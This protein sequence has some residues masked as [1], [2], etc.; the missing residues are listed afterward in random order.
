[1]IVLTCGT[2][3]LFHIGHLKVLQRARSLGSKLIVGVSS[4]ALN[5]TKKQRKPIYS[6]DQRMEIVSNLKCVDEVFLE[7]T[8]EDKLTYLQE[9]NAKIFVIG[10]DWEGKFDWLKDHGI[11]VCYLQRTPMI[12]TTAIIETIKQ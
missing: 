8:L 2:F 7:E 3:D 4:D 11:Q 1:M 12:S 5:V 9:H 6:Q 10:D